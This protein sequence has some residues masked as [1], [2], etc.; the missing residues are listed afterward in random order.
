MLR[1]VCDSGLVLI[2]KDKKVRISEPSLQIFWSNVVPFDEGSLK[3]NLF[4]FLLK[5]TPKKKSNSA[6][7]E[8]CIDSVGCKKVYAKI[9]ATFLNYH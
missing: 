9:K 5:D 8:K 3:N 6:S 4:C 2:L 7:T 1:H